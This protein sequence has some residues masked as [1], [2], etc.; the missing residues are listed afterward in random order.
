MNLAKHKRE[1]VWLGIG[2]S[3]E[4]NTTQT[5]KGGRRR[6]A[7]H[8]AEAV[9]DFARGGAALW[10]V[11]PRMG[12]VHTPFIRPSAPRVRRP[13]GGV[14]PAG[15]GIDT[16]RKL[17]CKTIARTRPGDRMPFVKVSP[18]QGSSETLRKS[19]SPPLLPFP[20]GRPRHKGHWV[21]GGRHNEGTCTR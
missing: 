15:I 13:K 9:S 12:A 5:G 6:R 7:G 16:Q 20:R 1:N 2:L 21:G 17:G 3:M 4:K 11:P 18:F 10:P 19:S 8:P 14:G